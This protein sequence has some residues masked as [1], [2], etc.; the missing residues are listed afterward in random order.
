MQQIWSQLQCDTQHSKTG[1]SLVTLL[2]M[3]VVTVCTSLPFT[4]RRPPL[5]CSDV[6]AR[7][8]LIG[9][10]LASRERSARSSA[11]SA[12]VPMVLCWRTAEPNW[13]KIICF[14]WAISVTKP[15]VY[16]APAYYSILYQLAFGCLVVIYKLGFTNGF[17]IF[18]CSPINERQSWI[19]LV[20]IPSAGSKSTHLWY[21][22]DRDPKLVRWEIRNWNVHL[23]GS[24]INFTHL[25]P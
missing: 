8:A 24:N 11:R 12:M 4:C 10:P 20:C 17:N 19:V 15:T 16:R 22:Q 7:G 25:Y 23:G 6:S 9:V 14:S 1:Y 5:P 2:D 21:L 18:D 3:L 13:A